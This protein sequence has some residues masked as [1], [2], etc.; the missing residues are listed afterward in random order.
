MIFFNVQTFLSLIRSHLFILLVSL[1]IYLFIFGGARSSLLS[2]G[3]LWLQWVGATLR[4]RAQAPGTQA[5]GAAAR[6]L[7][8]CGSWT[9]ATCSMWDLLGLGIT[10][11]SL[12]IGGQILIHCTT[13]EVPHVFISVSITLGDRSKKN[14]SAIYNMS[15][16]ILFVKI[17][18][19]ILAVVWLCG[20]TQ[21]FSSCGKRGLLS[22]WGARGSLCSSLSCCR[23]GELDAWASVVAVYGLR[24]CGSRALEHR[25]GN[26][27]TW[28]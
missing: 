12:A 21:A 7:R 23:A 2:M 25:L 14:I 28:V 10:P 19:F 6:G 26:C 15:K 11:L 20:C 4:F 17:Y 16:S 1:C 13:K 5:S 18:L 22:G 27:D 8:S 24:S 3:F 9:I